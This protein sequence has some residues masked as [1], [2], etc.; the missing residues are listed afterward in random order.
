MEIKG[1][2]VWMV[3]YVYVYVSWWLIHGVTHLSPEGIWNEL[4]QLISHFPVD[5]S[6]SQPELCCILAISQLCG[7]GDPCAVHALKQ[8]LEQAV[9]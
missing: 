1:V 6:F 9:L 3:I 8:G 4:L 7:Q 2:N 5:D